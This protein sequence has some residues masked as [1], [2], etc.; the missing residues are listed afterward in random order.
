MNTSIRRDQGAA[1][2]PAFGTFP[3]LAALVLM[4]VLGAGS[5][6][7]KGPGGGFTGPADGGYTGP[8]PA[9]ATVAEAKSMADDSHVMLRGY[10]VQQL[11]KDDY[12]FKDDSGTITVEIK[13]KE[14]AGQE[15]GPTD[16]V[17]IWGEVDKDWNSVE[18]EVK[19]LTK[20]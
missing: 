2:R 7:A 11:G 17:E 4:L 13:A 6:M 19:R 20:Q 14:W 16:L 15:V 18:I 8:G 1:A 5:A 9:M 3:A 12:L 10:L